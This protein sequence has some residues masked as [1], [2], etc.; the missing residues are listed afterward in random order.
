[1]DGRRYRIAWG[2]ARLL[3]A[4]ALAAPLAGCP[5][6]KPT[7]EE[8]WTRIDFTATSLTN[9]QTLPPGQVPITVGANITYRSIVTGFAVAE[10]RGSSSVTAGSVGIRPNADRQHMAEDIQRMLASSVTL[11]R[12]TRAVTGWD[13]LIQ[14]IDFAFTGSVPAVLDSTGAPAGLFLVCY[15]GSGAK[16]RRADGTDSLIVTPFNVD[17]YELLPIGLSLTP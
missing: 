1:M 3:L 11:G 7:I 10:L 12:A 9:G 16:L 4:A 15:L 2:A 5:L 13:H 8:R 6:D 14:H 17:R